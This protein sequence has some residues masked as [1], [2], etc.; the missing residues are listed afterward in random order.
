MFEEIKK[1][2]PLAE[3][4]ETCSK[5]SKDG[6]CSVSWCKSCPGSDH[7]NESMCIRNGWRCKDSTSHSMACKITEQ[8]AIDWIKKHGS[9]YEED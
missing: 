9:L 1:H 7:H 6:S 2:V 3:I 4:L 8:N 5:L